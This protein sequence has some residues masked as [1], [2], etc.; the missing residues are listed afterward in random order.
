MSL[1]KNIGSRLAARAM[2]RRTYRPENALQIFSSPRG[3]STWLMGMLA[4]LPGVACVWEPLHERRGVV[5]NSWGAR[6]HPE[7]LTPADMDVLEQVLSGNLANAWTCS[8]TTL[9]E[10]READ[11]L[12]IKYVRANSLLPKMLERWEF[13]H[14]P[15]LLMRHPWDVVQS[16]VRAFGPRP[17]DLRVEQAYAGH[18]QI[19]QRWATIQAEPDPCVRQLHLWCLLNAPIWKS[20]ADDPA[21]VSVDYHDL[22]L[23]PEG[24]LID[25]LEQLQWQA[26]ERSDWTPQ[27]FVAGL[28]ARAGSDTDFRGDY[29]QNQQDQLWKN[30]RRLTPERRASLQNVLDSYGVTRYVMD[31]IRPQM[32]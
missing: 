32:P 4:Q 17:M 29:L 18:R 27:G 2:A 19:Q 12:L 10:A 26:P 8:R 25:V 9:R 3:G 16:Q 14:K 24:G 5:P 21:V 15:I 30:L 11:Q 20:C 13:R 23:D 31:D 1:A 22:V 7:A 28:N 6:P